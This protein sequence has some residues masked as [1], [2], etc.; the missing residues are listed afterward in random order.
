M[1]INIPTSVFLYI[2]A[3]VVLDLH[4]LKEF[5]LL[6]F[7]VCR[8]VMMLMNNYLRNLYDVE[9]NCAEFLE[10]IRF[11]IVDLDFC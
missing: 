11:C 10:D 6:F 4:L 9:T 2:S 7:L 3:S 1:L 5:F 8:S